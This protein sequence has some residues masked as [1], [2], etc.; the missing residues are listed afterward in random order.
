MGHD[1]AG[2]VEIGKSV[3]DETNTV[4]ERPLTAKPNLSFGAEREVIG[5]TRLN[6]AC[7]VGR[8]RFRFVQT[9]LKA[10]GILRK[11]KGIE[12]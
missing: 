3:V 6:R 4:E 11:Y 7:S 8:H 1:H 12:R 2:F 9:K 10:I 5:F